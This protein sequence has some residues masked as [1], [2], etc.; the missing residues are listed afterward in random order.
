M[1]N[2][3][4][5]KFGLDMGIDILFVDIANNKTSE[6]KASPSGDGF[7][8]T[9]INTLREVCTTDPESCYQHDHNVCNRCGAYT[10]QIADHAGRM[11]E[12]EIVKCPQCGLMP[13]SATNPAIPI[14]DD[15]ATVAYDHGVDESAMVEIGSDSEDHDCIYYLEPEDRALPSNRCACSCH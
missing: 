11:V 14:C 2:D 3:K 15:C 5:I 10:S 1:P 12:S 9:E 8:L 7:K 6:V 13:Q 4:T